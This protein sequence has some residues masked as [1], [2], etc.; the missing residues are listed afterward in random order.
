MNAT[1]SQLVQTILQVIIAVAVPVVTAMVIAGGNLLIQRI[2]MKMSNEQLA[3]ADALVGRFVSA[4]QQYNLSGI[5][6]QTGE[7]KKAWV[8]GKVQ[9]ALTA[10]G[11]TI[12]AGML[13]DM[14]EANILKGAKEP[15]AFNLQ[16]LIPAATP[17]APVAPVTEPV[18][19][20]NKEVGSG[21]ARTGL[22]GSETHPT[23]NADA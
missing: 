5:L 20:E 3:F 17:V 1:D 12:D 9:A 14:V 13:A 2:K 15:V 23:G 4:A 22:V 11:I 18:G 6:T 8:V 16:A 19:S 10:Q 7:E 21:Q